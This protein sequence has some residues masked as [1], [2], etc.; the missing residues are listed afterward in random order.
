MVSSPKQPSVFFKWP[1][2]LKF[3]GE[4]PARFEPVITVCHQ[5]S[6]FFR[7]DSGASVISFILY[8]AGTFLA[9]TVPAWMFLYPSRKKKSSKPFTPAA[10]FEAEVNNGESSERLTSGPVDE[11]GKILDLLI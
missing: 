8:S 7:L 5:I 11:D 9:I 1:K 6:T 3:T 4:I 10:N 2:A